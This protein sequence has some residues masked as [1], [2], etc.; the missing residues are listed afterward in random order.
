MSISLSVVII[1]FNEQHNIDK[2]LCSVEKVANE[3]VVIDSFSTDNT[4]NICAKHNVTFIKNK[5]NGHIEQKNF[6]I[7]KAS[8]PYILS[9]D[10]DERLTNKSIQDILSVKQ[11]WE[12][13]AYSFKRLNNFCGHWV[14]YGSW[15]P[16]RKVRLFKKTAGSWQGENPH[17]EF[18]TKKE[19]TVT[20]LSSDILHFTF[21]SISQHI[22][23][24]N[25]FTDISSQQLFKKGKKSSLLKILFSPI[26]KFI[27][28]YLFKLGFMD[29]LYGFIIAYNSSHAKFQKYTKLYFLQKNSTK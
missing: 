9:L 12:S 17:D 8:H 26:I 29:G 5:F 27:R 22:K 10:A 4:E 7:S 2:C 14:K 18:I 6:A 1:T 3:I 13:D 15:Y 20:S 21:T 24:I 28:D 23:Q 11:K 19:A 16:D 25:Y